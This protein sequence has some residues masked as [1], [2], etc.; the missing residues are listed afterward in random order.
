MQLQQINKSRYR[1]HLN[2]VIIAFIISFALLALGI[3]QALIVL[4]SA[5][6]AD[7]FWL[8]VFGV[9]LAL[10]I[11]LS[12]INQLKHHQFMHEVYYVWRLKQQINLIY[13]KLKAIKALA[14][15]DNNTDAMIILTFYYQACRQLYELDDNTITLDSLN[16]EQDKLAQHLQSLSLELNASQYDTSLLNIV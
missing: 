11:C 5:P 4:I 6:G 12:V 3:G 16:R 15:D 9:A 1:A 10:M 8:N 14:F 13:R 7:N 2:K